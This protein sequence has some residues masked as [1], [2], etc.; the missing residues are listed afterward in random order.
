M[1]IED[2]KTA[3]FKSLREYKKVDEIPP[4]S[5]AFHGIFKKMDSCRDVQ[6][7]GTIFQNFHISK[8]KTKNGV[9]VF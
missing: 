8:F 6:S 3:G 1:S 9:L 2:F 4:L 5:S 7:I